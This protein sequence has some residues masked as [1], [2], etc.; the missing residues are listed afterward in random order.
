MFFQSKF[1]SGGVNLAKIIDA[2]IGGAGMG[3]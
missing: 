1:T 2:M 3:I